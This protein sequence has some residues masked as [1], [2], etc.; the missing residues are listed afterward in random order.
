MPFEAPANER[1]I[2]ALDFSDFNEAH[3]FQIKLQAEAPARWFKLGHELMDIVGPMEAI[4]STALD[5]RA[6]V[7]TDRKLVDI[8]KTCEKASANYFARGAT[9]FNCYALGGRPTMEGVSKARDL[10]WVETEERFK[11]VQP[12]S[13]RPRRPVVLA[14]TIPTDW[15]HENLCEVGLASDRSTIDDKT[16]REVRMQEDFDRNVVCLSRLAQ[17]SGCDGVICSPLEAA[18][19]RAACGEDFLIVTPGVRPEWAQADGQTRFTTPGEAMQNGADM[20]VI[21]SPIRKPPKEIETPARAFAL[22]VE[23]I[24]QALERKK[25]AS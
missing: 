9:M 15:T 13:A 3:T 16:L 25:E 24:E 6:D 23:E 17:D 21:G 10:H 2:V 22:I 14:V 12:E 1:V 11:N 4:R 20:L 7:F 18:S 8:R 5:D 19:V